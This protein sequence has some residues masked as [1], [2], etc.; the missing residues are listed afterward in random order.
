MKRL[1]LAASFA[2]LLLTA[3]LALADGHRHHGDRHHHDHDYDRDYDRDHDRRHKHWKHRDYRRGD[4]IEVVYLEPRYYVDDYAYYHLRQ[5]PRGHR[6]V[7]DDEGRFIL[8]AVATGIIADILL[9]H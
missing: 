3:P 7:R 6:W 4:R 1:I 8:V 9:H 5:P 2:T